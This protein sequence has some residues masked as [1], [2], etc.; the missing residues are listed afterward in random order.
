PRWQ[1]SFV[2]ALTPDDRCHLNGLYVDAGMPKYVTTLGETDTANGWRPD[3]A[4]GGILIDVPSGQVVVR[5]LS[6]PHSPRVYAGRVWLLDSG[7]GR[8][9]VVDV[10]R[11][12]CDVV[13]ELP[14]FTRGLSFF[15][16][17]AFV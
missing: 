6:M 1:P 3:K 15:G 5:R 8:L 4:S 14:G 9:V 11:G 13:A 10:T 2:T 17:Y 16:P 12:K 7:T